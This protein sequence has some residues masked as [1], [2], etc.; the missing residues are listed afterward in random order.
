MET[1]PY[2][3]KGFKSMKARVAALALGSAL[4][5]TAL[6]GWGSAPSVHNAAQV[7]HKLVV[8]IYVSPLI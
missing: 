3:R 4:A 7:K 8:T 2:F 6:G 5:T 1:Y